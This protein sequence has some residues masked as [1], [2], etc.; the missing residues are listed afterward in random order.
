[1]IHKLAPHYPPDHPLYHRRELNHSAYPEFPAR[2][3]TELDQLAR[4]MV[5]ELPKVTA[6]VC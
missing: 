3:L 6:P 1:M 5:K 2:I 4:A